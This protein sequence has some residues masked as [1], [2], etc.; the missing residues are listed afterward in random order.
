MVMNKAWIAAT[1][2]LAWSFMCMSALAGQV[3]LDPHGLAAIG[4][5]DERFQSYNVEMAEII[6]GRFWKPYAHMKVDPTKSPRANDA[7]TQSTGTNLDLH[8]TRAPT[9]LGNRRLRV[10]AAALGPAY[11]RVSGSW[12]NDV[13]FQNDDGPKLPQP[14]TGFQNVLTRAQWRGVIEFAHAVN[15]RLVTSFAINAPVRDTTGA[16]TPVQARPFVE[17]TRSI[18]GEIYAAELFNEPNFSGRTGGPANYDAKAFARD[19]AV[20][21]TFVAEALPAMKI[22]GPGD[23]SAARM[24]QLPLT[25]DF[26][27]AEPRPRFDIISY[28]YYGAVSKRCAPSGKPPGTL[29]ELALTESLLAGTE[30]AMLNRKVVRDGYAPGAPLWLTEVAGSACG[31]SPWDS[32]FLDTFRYLDQLGR[33]ARGGVSAVFHNTLAASEYGL[34]NEAT[35]EPRPNFWAALL[36]RKLMG[37]VVLDAGE[38]RPGIHVYAHCLRDIPGGVS[39]LA[40]NN[41]D[42]PSTFEAPLAAELYLLTATP[43]ENASVWLNGTLLAMGSNDSFPALL[44][45][46]VSQA[47]VTLPPRSIGFI[48]LPGAGNANCS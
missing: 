26:M 21:R 36:W 27:A 2:A 25:E 47:K 4:R 20:F 18:G 9:D 29:P 39:V 28:H 19:S 46:H 31:G 10:L 15:A 41:G 16:W 32:T 13:Y 11:I 8:E 30:R 24:V 17:Y 44:P 5:V 23:T 42:K 7:N 40:V 3:S 14:P 22:V 37:P 45:R 48:A 43:T 34:I 6:G 12:A 1:A 33:L 35:M 38:I